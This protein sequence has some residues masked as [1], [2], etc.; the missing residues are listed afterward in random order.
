MSEFFNMGGYAVYV[1]SSYGLTAVL[2]GWVF[3]SPIVSK[4]NIIQQLR[5]KYRQQERQAQVAKSDAGAEITQ[6]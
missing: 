4:K 6:E 5:T 3:V 2:L 1:W